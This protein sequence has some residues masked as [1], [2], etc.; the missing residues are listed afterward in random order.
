MVGILAGLFYLQRA[1]HDTLAAASD[2]IGEA[3]VADQALAGS[4]APPY[5]CAVSFLLARGGAVSDVSCGLAAVND[6]GGC[7]VDR[8]L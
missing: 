4:L 8:A 3:S 5:S 2:T 7:G 6:G 1:R